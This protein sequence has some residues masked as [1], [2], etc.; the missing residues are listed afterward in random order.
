MHLMVHLYVKYRVKV[1][2]LYSDKC[3]I[4]YQ[5]KVANYFNY[6]IDVIKNSTHH[7]PCPPI[8]S[9]C[10]FVFAASYQALLVYNLYL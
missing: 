4:K 8:L 1:K 7:Y 2:V 10:L 3:Q 5:I 6:F 9:V